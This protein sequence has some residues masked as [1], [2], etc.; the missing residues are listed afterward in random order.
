VFKNVDLL[1]VMVAGLATSFP[2]VSEELP[3]CNLLHKASRNFSI[4]ISDLT[5][6]HVYERLIFLRYTNR[7]CL[8]Q[9]AKP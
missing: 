6:A 9:N 7:Y 5:R 1:R 2:L 3:C 4:Y 8:L